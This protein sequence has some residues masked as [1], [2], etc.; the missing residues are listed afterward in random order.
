MNAANLCPSPVGVSSQVT[1]WTRDID[2]DCSFD[3]RAKFKGLL[4]NSRSKIASHLGV[5]PA[6]IALVRNTSEGNCIINNGFNLGPG[7]EVLLWDQN[8]PT[9]NVAWDV[10]A[11]RF[12]FRVRRVATPKDASSSGDL[13]DPFLRAITARTRVLAVSLVSN[14]S[15]IRLPGQQ[16]GEV[17]RKQGIH[18]HLDGAQVWGA[19]HVN[20]R[21]LQCDS[22]AA[23]S[24]KWFMGPKEAGVL[25]V[26]QERIAEIWPGHVAPG[27]G[28]DADPDVVGARKFESMG[29]RDDACLAALAT[30]AEFHFMIGPK[31]IEKRILELTDRLKSGALDL[32]LRLVTPRPT[33][34]SAGV[35][36]IDVPAEKRGSVSARLYSE[37][38]IAAAPTGGLRLCPHIYNTDAHVERA[39]KALKI[40]GQESI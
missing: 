22:F 33:T 16:L 12:G 25:F 1:H 13:V 14:V 32:G 17:C 6:E 18:L 27:W 40:V 35:C 38:G 9:N 26:R 21:E 20:L 4:E 19:L 39:L 2:V 11:E 36:V 3:N 24:H 29:Q 31:R 34:L 15:G 7:D 30:A 5:S 37:H 23:S 10:R 28:D 8:H